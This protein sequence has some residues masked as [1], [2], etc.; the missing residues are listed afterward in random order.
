[1]V[2]APNPNP[3][4]LNAARTAAFLI[5]NGGVMS[6]RWRWVKGEP[7]RLVSWET[8]SAVEAGAAGFDRNTIIGSEQPSGDN[9]ARWHQHARTAKHFLFH[10]GLRSANAQRRH[11]VPFQCR[12]V[13]ARCRKRERVEA[14]L[15]QFYNMDSI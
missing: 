14:E 13:S 6:R 1:M 8:P 12:K 2:P 11:S 4:R 10:F 15:R 7:C 3:F 5:D 9:S